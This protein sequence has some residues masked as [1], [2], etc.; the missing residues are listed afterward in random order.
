M[1]EHAANVRVGLASPTGSTREWFMFWD[2][3]WTGEKCLDMRLDSITRAT[4]KEEAARMCGVPVAQVRVICAN[5]YS[6]DYDWHEA[7]GVAAR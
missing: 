6:D 4:A 3:S 1:I 5:Q 7:R 2:D